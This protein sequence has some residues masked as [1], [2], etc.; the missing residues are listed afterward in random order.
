MDQP[1]VR[2]IL[3]MGGLVAQPLIPADAL[4]KPGMRIEVDGVVPERA[5][6]LLCEIYQGRADLPAGG[7]EVIAKL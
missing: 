1:A 7:E 5:G 3:E 2:Q 6:P 4:G